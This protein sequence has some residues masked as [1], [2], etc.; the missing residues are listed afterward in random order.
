MKLCRFIASDGSGPNYGLIEG[1][2]VSPMIDADP[3]SGR[4]RKQT[5]KFPLDEVRLLAPAEPSKIVCVGRNYLKHA[6][7]LGNELPSEPMLFLKP[8]SSVIG[9]NDSIVLP[10]AS[11]Q[12]EHEAE[13][14]VV[15]GR[16]SFR[17]SE[18]ENSLSYVLGY[19]CL[20]DV[21]ARD[22][23][24]KDIQFT[25][26]KSF[27]TFCP[28]GPWLITDLNPEDIEVTCRVNGELKQ[29]GR[30]SEMAF[31]VEFLVRYISHIMTL[32]PG[33]V[34]ATGTPAG[35]GPLRPGDRVEVGIEGIG[36]LSNEVIGF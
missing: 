19:T 13:L 34:I 32:N 14:G 27:D 11:Q 33:D 24:R 28:L 1:D 25:R 4:G 6:K 7:E 29:S 10:A 9:P 21:T 5:G 18:G 30:T 8:P 2:V 15:I 31:P 16:T 20:N 35:V 17:I 36:I 26:S 3:F 23:Q 12:V 22:L